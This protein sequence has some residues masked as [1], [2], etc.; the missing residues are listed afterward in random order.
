[1]KKKKIKM[2]ENKIKYRHELNIHFLFLLNLVYFLNSNDAQEIS[3]TH[4]FD[5]RKMNKMK[6]PLRTY[7]LKFRFENVFSL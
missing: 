1:M 7:L 3:L 6:L 4:C 5:F 2:S